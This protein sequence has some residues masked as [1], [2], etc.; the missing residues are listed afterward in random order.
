MP[1]PVR[2]KTWHSQEN[3]SSLENEQLRDQMKRQNVQIEDTK[4]QLHALEDILDKRR[5]ELDKI[6]AE[7]IK[8]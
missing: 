5:K 8:M 2:R 1:Q 6:K 7:T 3:M 4:W